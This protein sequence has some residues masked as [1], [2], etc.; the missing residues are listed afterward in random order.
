MLKNYKHKDDGMKI[1]TFSVVKSLL[2]KIRDVTYL[3][4][5]K[6]ALVYGLFSYTMD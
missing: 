2:S 3:P 5:L 6:I 4:A 1:K